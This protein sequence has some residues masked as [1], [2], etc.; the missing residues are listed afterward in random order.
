MVVGVI[1]MGLGQVNVLF[2]EW[3]VFFL[4]QL[5]F[6][7]LIYTEEEITEFKTVG[8]KL[9][10]GARERSNNPWAESEICIFVYEREKTF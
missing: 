1:P 7:G 2:T 8:S 3:N 9:S 10:Y 4:L 5:I 6:A